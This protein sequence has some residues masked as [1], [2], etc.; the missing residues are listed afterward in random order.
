MS[1]TETTID[2]EVLDQ[3]IEDVG[4]E[5]VD[6]LLRTFMGEAVNRMGRIRAAARA[7]NL[8][9]L[10]EECHTLKGSASS[11]GAVEV[12]RQ[13]ERIVTACLA[14]DGE[15][16]FGRVDGL[17]GSVN[18]ALIALGERISLGAQGAAAPAGPAPDSRD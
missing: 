2:G 1:E 9:A 10:H 12:A 7:Q 8:T 17:E 13:A 14:G 18:V 3:L 6:R 16:A 5:S 15:G 4:L 11:F